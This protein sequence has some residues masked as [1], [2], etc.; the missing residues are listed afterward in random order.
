[1]STPMRSAVLGATFMSF[2]FGV[3]GGSVG[4]NALIKWVFDF[5]FGFEFSLALILLI[6]SML[7]CAS[8][9]LPPQYTFLHDVQRN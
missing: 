2:A 6:R 7:D 3:I 5:G 8:G 1:M 4:L 9:F